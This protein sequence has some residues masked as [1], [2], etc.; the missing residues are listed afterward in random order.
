MN[1]LRSKK[2]IGSLHGLRG[3]AALTVLIGH[4]RVFAGIPLPP[5]AAAMGVLLFFVLSGFLMAHL[6]IDKT[7]T[8][9]SILQYIRARIARIYPLFGLLCIFSCVVFYLGIPFSYEMDISQLLLHLLGVGSIRTIWTIST[10]FQF[11]LIFILFWVAYSKITRNRDAIFIIGLILVILLLWVAGFP[12][13]RIAIT[14][15]LQV[16]LVGMIA[17]LILPHIRTKSLLSAS[18]ILFPLLMV[19]YFAAYFIT[20]KTIGARYVYHSVPL[21]IV[22]GGI[23][24]TAVLSENTFLGKALGSKPLYWLGEVSFGVYLLH[25]PVMGFLNKV[26]PESMNLHWSF[27]LA[28]LL[29]LVAILSHVAYLLIERPGRTFIRDKVISLK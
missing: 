24:L 23:V 4:S 20:P 10:E 15:Y 29:F 22:M 11:Y 7:P 6:Y 16:F 17:A 1:E 14:G 8:Y 9:G 12:G 5:M 18:K 28:L 3:I 27:K 2:H 13:G 25:R 21:I 19:V 26:I